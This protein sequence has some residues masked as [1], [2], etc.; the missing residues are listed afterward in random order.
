MNKIVTKKTARLLSTLLAV[1]IVI[2]VM[3]GGMDR[4]LQ[5]QAESETDSE[6]TS[7]SVPKPDP[8]EEYRVTLSDENGKMLPIDG[9]NVTM[10]ISGI[11]NK[12]DGS[13]SEDEIG[14]SFNATTDMSG[15]AVFQGTIIPE[16]KYDITFQ[17]DGTACNNIAELKDVYVEKVDFTSE[18]PDD[19]PVNGVLVTVLEND[20]D[21][22]K[23]KTVEYK[24]TVKNNTEFTEYSN[25]NIKA[26][27]WI[28]GDE[29]NKISPKTNLRN[30]D[31]EPSFTFDCRVGT[32]YDFQITGNPFNAVG[33]VHVS[34]GSENAE[35][36]LEQEFTV[37]QFTVK[38]D[39]DKF[40]NATVYD[41][42]GEEYQGYEDEDLKAAAE[43]AAP[44]EN[45]SDYEETFSYGASPKYLVVA[46]DGYRI[47]KF[48]INDKSIDNS[49]EG[50]NNSTEEINAEQSNSYVLK[51]DNID[52]SPLISAQID[53]KTYNISFT[54]N[55][56][57]EVSLNRKSDELDNLGGVID[58]ENINEHQE[59]TREASVDETSDYVIS[60][61]AAETYHIQEFKY[62]KKNNDNSANN[63]NTPFT[64][65]LKEQ[66][67]EFPQNEPKE[68]K[69]EI[70]DV[71]SDYEFTI[72]F[73]SDVFNVTAKKSE[74]GTV[75]FNKSNNLITETEDTIKT[76]YII[77]DK[78]I[79]TVKPEEGYHINEIKIT[80]TEIVEKTEQE[81]ESEPD[82]KY[83]EIKNTNTLHLLDDELKDNADGTFTFEI[84]DVRANYDIEVSYDEDTN[85]SMSDIKITKPYRKDDDSE[86][87]TRY[88]YRSEN[89]DNIS[90]SYSLKGVTDDEITGVKIDYLT[91]GNN[92]EGQRPENSTVYKTTK[93]D[94][95]FTQQI[96]DIQIYYQK[97]WHKIELEKPVLLILD[98]TAPKNKGGLS[99][100]PDAEWT[101]QSSVKISG[102]LDLTNENAV[103][104]K[105][106]CVIWSK[107]SALDETTLRNI[108]LDKLSS[109]KN[110]EYSKTAISNGKFSF[111]VKGEQKVDYYVYAL[112][113]AGNIFTYNTVNVGIDTTMPMIENFTVRATDSNGSLV[114]FDE[115]GATAADTIT[116][117]V[118]AYDFRS[119]VSSVTLCGYDK[120]EK[121]TVNFTAKEFISDDSSNSTTAIFE[122]SGRQN[123]SL[124]AIAQ[125]AAG[126]VIERAV[127][128]E[129]E[130]SNSY[131]GDVMVG[132]GNF[133]V[134]IT[135][136]DVTYTDNQDRD[137]Y[138]ENDKINITYS[139]AEDFVGLS[140]VDF[141]IITDANGEKKS[142][143]IAKY[144]KVFN[145]EYSKDNLNYQSDND[146]ITTSIGD[147]VNIK[148]ICDDNNI[149]LPEGKNTVEITVYSRTKNST[150][151]ISKKSTYDFYI[152]NTAPQ[153]TKITFTKKQTSA[154]IVLNVLS[155][156]LFANGDLNVDVEF[157]DGNISGSSS[158]KKVALSYNNSEY[159]KKE[160]IAYSA[161][162]TDTNKTVRFTIPL[163][164]VTSSDKKVYLDGNIT[165]NAYDCVGHASGEMTPRA[166]DSDPN[167]TG[168][169]Q[170]VMVENID[171][172]IA[173]FALPTQY[174]DNNETTVNANTFNNNIWYNT[175]IEFGIK[176]TDDDSGVGSVEANIN[177]TVIKGEDGSDYLFN[178]YNSDTPNVSKLEKSF[179][180]NETVKTN[181]SGVAMNSDGSYT[182]TVRAADN[183]GNTAKTGSNEGRT[184]TIYKD[185]HAPTITQFE[186]LTDGAK[187]GDGAPNDNVELTDYGYYF[188]VDTVVRIHT[189][190]VTENDGKVPS[191]GVNNIYFK[192]VPVGSAEA[193][194]EGSVEK[195][196]ADGTYDFVVP[197]NFKG[198]I[199][200]KADDNVGNVVTGFVTPSGTIIESPEQHELENHITISRPSAPSS[201]GSGSPLYAGPVDVT[202]TIIDT[203]SGID[204]A[205][206]TINNHT[207]SVNVENSQSGADSI[208]DWHID[209]REYN[210]VT[211][212]S[213][214]INVAD[215]INDIPISV[216]MT[217]RSG[218]TSTAS[219]SFSIDTT[220][221]SITIKWDENV[222]PDETNN[223]FFNKA[224]T[225]TVTVTERNFSNHSFTPNITNTDGTIPSFSGWVDSGSGDDATHVTTVTFSADG[226]YEFS[227]SCAD[228]VG[229]KSTETPQEK[230][231]MDFT[232]PTVTVTY[233]NNSS[234]NS[235]Y[236]AKD[237]IAT[238]TINEH[239][240]D[241][242]RAVVNITANDDGKSITAPTV[243]NW[244]D[245]GNSHIA[246]VKFSDN[247]LYTLS[248][249]VT[250]KAGNKGSSGG[251]QRFYIDK[252]APSIEFA[253]V[254]DQSANKG[255]ITPI[256]YLTDKNYD[257]N[258]VKITLTGS[259]HGKGN[260][261]YKKE[262]TDYES[263]GE[264]VEY[265]NFEV[266]P[267][268]DDIY[269]LAVTLTD[270]AGNKS[271]DK[272][273]FS[274]N[275]YGS[276]YTIDDE[277]TK[278]KLGRGNYYNEEFDVKLTETNVDE[279]G[280]IKITSVRSGNPTTLSEGD[281]YETV[282]DTVNGSWH[283]NQYIIKSGV[284]KNNGDYEILAYSVDKA[285]NVNENDTN[286]EEKKKTPI[287]FGIDKENPIIMAQNF[288]IGETIK[289]NIVNGE[290]FV[291]EVEIKDDILLNDYSVEIDGKQVDIAP[292]N[293]NSSEDDSGNINNN[294]FHFNIPQ[295]NDRHNIVIT[296]VDKAGNIE[297][298]SC[299]GNEGILVSTN[300]FV[301]WFNNRPLF[302]GTIIVGAILIAGIIILIAA[303]SRRK[304][305]Q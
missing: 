38:F 281:D 139:A 254:A 137:W 250:D 156:G 114:T 123:L 63:D 209:R 274:A 90:V 237:R 68:F 111:T 193:N 92:A 246:K 132:T 134:N 267:E 159:T 206:V 187:F 221:P 88:I 151:Y 285:S 211:Q 62:R 270:L 24:I 245:S 174:K 78:I 280:D 81:L 150:S 99:K 268:V 106:D 118:E 125:D 223:D 50:N 112:D 184:I 52:K 8:L 251:Q 84:E 249:N 39:A 235:N 191:S 176:V 297:T 85:L 91:N 228:D 226:D 129:K 284:F 292:V 11:N 42:S 203:Y 37:K 59:S 77:G 80:S 31:T 232:V 23:F 169:I 260:L 142:H 93:Y 25:Y 225:A 20:I 107:G 16:R 128:M 286:D 40:E 294:L 69:K 116:V 155:F 276:V 204:S 293:D 180:N 160:N 264:M 275:R 287:E 258:S 189:D 109:S 89:L 239:N 162:D 185:T 146:S 149:T 252:T 140:S 215:N 259:N 217:D 147:T 282:S 86:L 45:L 18:N 26:E 96:T 257:S 104:S 279:I 229:N 298:L 17:T 247:A 227:A 66:E 75:S 144:S 161:N 199:M 82:E 14:T 33:P 183:A 299:T 135:A 302:I 178:S 55:S 289:D 41:F 70:N 57:G 290:Y 234:K 141:N 58:I 61:A 64:D 167:R 177:G 219:D 266:K 98:S 265:S 255:N 136:N 158:Y 186:F 303:L 152:D 12:N 165:V 138:S 21:R 170:N 166:N 172:E 110:G 154:Q 248:V 117:E 87:Y 97:Q 108:Q 2:N 207:Y 230:F 54:V 95:T 157:N 296:A 213:C 5:A 163:D 56:K 278:E 173:E 201:T 22:S 208:N 67:E 101:N 120:V 74:N 220:P 295:G 124:S 35:K 131:N 48:T 218:N 195:A 291:A 3:P 202:F 130:N 198:Q 13:A 283:Q 32:E 192:A 304:R 127:P 100:N 272:I 261:D 212:M 73:S 243:S 43:E 148:D 10:T 168:D 200:A 164:E 305:S 72:T 15:I 76:Q 94:V 44:M 197:A 30:G 171:P 115:F 262:K 277:A 51:F 53:K 60:A 241:S 271:E 216:T 175:D 288:E 222:K 126:N 190:D 122:I 102:E 133:N 113:E 273:T 47:S 205:E 153:I 194:V 300:A 145:K 121:K 182:L 4:V 1:L 240:F 214:T 6:S 242:S 143:H 253:G 256:I 9:V 233:D 7:A 236:F 34:I 27:G 231:T 79:A 224:R 46:N 49:G 181:A 301:L 28:T 71:H 188:K 238:I 103:T 19:A 105:L 29:N 179:S 65:A 210:L 263:S 36:V 83:K 244:E 119:G 196:N 269:T